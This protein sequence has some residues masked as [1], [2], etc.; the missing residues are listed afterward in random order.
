MQAAH[1]NLVGALVEPAK[2]LDP[3]DI[4]Q[5]IGLHQSHVQHRAQR[6]AAGHDLDRHALVG[7]QFKSRTDFA[8]TSVVEIDRLHARAP[9]ADL[10]GCRFLFLASSI[11][12]STRRGVIGE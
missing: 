3:G 7:D 6:L 12:S 9:S 10:E 8:G 5:Q 11:A 1:H 4:D 2:L